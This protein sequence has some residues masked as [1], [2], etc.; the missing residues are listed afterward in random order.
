MMVGYYL[1]KVR[2]SFSDLKERE[3]ISADVRLFTEKIVTLLTDQKISE[4]LNRCSPSLQGT[5]EENS[6]KQISKLFHEEQQNHTITGN[7][8]KVGDLRT[9]PDY[10]AHL[11]S[12]DDLKDYSIKLFFL[13]HRTPSGF[14][15]D[16]IAFKLK[17]PNT[18]NKRDSLGPWSINQLENKYHQGLKHA[19]KVLAP[20]MITLFGVTCIVLI[21]Q[22][23]A[24]WRLFTKADEP[25]WAALTPIY[26]SVVLARIGGKPGWWGILLVFTLPAPYI[27][28]LISLGVWILIC[29]G[30]AETFAK[31]RLFALGLCF[32]P[33]IF[34]PILAFSE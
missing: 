19:L 10:L 4:L 13:F 24:R 30:V 23:L 6:L 22:I 15:I 26:A 17:S 16:G 33:Y 14:L 28:P 32:L 29:M 11:E 2:S 25:G 27:G 8:I 3:N 9:D 7:C 20:G 34:F 18:S 21:I 31:S 1:L 12:T 5:E